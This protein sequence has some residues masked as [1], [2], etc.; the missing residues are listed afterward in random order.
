MFAHSLAVRDRRSSPCEKIHVSRRR[1]TPHRHLG[2]PHFGQLSVRR[3]C[4]TGDELVVE[5]L[6]FVETDVPIRAA[7]GDR[8][9]QPVAPEGIRAEIDHVLCIRLELQLATAQQ[10]M[11]ARGSCCTERPTIAVLKAELQSPLN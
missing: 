7:K 4:N 10:R 9:P 6:P 11:G 3:L 8:V 5:A 1:V 2:A